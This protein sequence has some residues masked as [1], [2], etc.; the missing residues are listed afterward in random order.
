MAIPKTISTCPHCGGQFS[1]YRSAPRR[2]CS[3]SCSSKTNNTHKTRTYVE[4]MAAR[5]ELFA[6][7]QGADECW[8]WTGRI[9]IGGYGIIQAIK[10][11]RVFAHRAAWEVVHGPIP[12]GL[13]IL[14]VCDVRNCINPKHLFLGTMAD[15]SADMVKKGRSIRGEQRWNAK[16]TPALVRD[17]RAAEGSQSTIAKRFGISRSYAGALRARVG[18]KH[19]L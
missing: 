8:L 7:T 3:H 1:H 12:D 4:R 15:N 16:L 14:H 19:L 18:W 6:A 2:F 11:Y 13:K 10:P 17:I 9:G 5:L